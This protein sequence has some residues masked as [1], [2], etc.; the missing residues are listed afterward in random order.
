ML[1][2]KGLSP[3]INRRVS[4]IAL[5][6]SSGVGWVTDPDRKSMQSDEGR[7]ITIV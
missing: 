4:R 2:P 7:V 1:T 3:L 6:K 5:R